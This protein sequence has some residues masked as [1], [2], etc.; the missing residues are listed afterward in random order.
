[1]TNKPEK[2]ISQLFTLQSYQTFFLVQVLFITGI[3]NSKFSMV[4][5]VVVMGGALFLT[6]RTSSGPF[7]MHLGISLG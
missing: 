6:R 3:R 5:V 2:E 7:S 4:V 1:M